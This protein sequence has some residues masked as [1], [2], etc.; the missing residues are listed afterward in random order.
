MHRNIDSLTLPEGLVNTKLA[1]CTLPTPPKV[2]DSETSQW[3]NVNK[4]FAF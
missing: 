4:E 1:G 3:R 2:S